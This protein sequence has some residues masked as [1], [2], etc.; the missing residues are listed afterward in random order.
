MVMFRGRSGWGY[1]VV[2]FDQQT[3]LCTPFARK[4][5]LFWH[6][7]IISNQNN[8]VQK[9]MVI[10]EHKNNSSC[11]KRHYRLVFDNNT[12][13]IKTAEAQNPKQ[14][15][16]Q[17]IYNTKTKLKNNCEIIMKQLVKHTQNVYVAKPISFKI[18]HYKKMRR[19]I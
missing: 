10:I 19:T 7:N 6:F 1:I 11:Y 15:L 9:Q 4:I 2:R 14:S 5:H 3:G 17:N 8:V 16:L 13:Q 12:F 18:K